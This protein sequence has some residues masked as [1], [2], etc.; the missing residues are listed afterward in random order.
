MSEYVNKKRKGF[1]V[2]GIYFRSK[3]HDIDK[4]VLR[5]ELIQDCT[6]FNLKYGMLRPTQEKFIKA[7]GIKKKDYSEECL[8]M[9]NRKFRYRKNEILTFLISVILKQ[10]TIQ[11]AMIKFNLS[12]HC[13]QSALK[14]ILTKEYLTYYFHKLHL[15]I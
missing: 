1:I 5:A 7:F 12:F 8:C 2:N 9:R 14:D 15:R 6:D 3:F 4:A 13:L 10:Y 11:D